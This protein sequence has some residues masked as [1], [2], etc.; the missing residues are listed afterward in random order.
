MAANRALLKNQLDL[1]SEPVWLTQVHGTHIVN[2]A[3][4]A[5]GVAADAAFTDQKNI[6]CGVMTADCLPVFFCSKDGSAVAVAHA[7]WRGL[8]AGILEAT[9]DSLNTQPDNILCWLGP[10]IGATKFEVGK[11]VREAFVTQQASSARAF[12]PTR[13]AH[14]LA[15]IYTLAKIK[16]KSVGITNVSGGD[17]CTY[18][19]SKRFYSYRRDGV[20]G[21]MAS[22]IWMAPSTPTILY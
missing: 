3:T 4:A 6:V 16:L 9:A 12:V 13:E 11:E 20:T 19:D 18:T 14:W 1:P 15:D 17:E 22:L 8:A 2:A 10:A 7:G 5:T 21:R